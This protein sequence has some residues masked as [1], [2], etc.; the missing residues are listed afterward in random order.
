MADRRLDP[1]C[2]VGILAS[3]YDEPRRRPGCSGRT[4]CSIRVG[5]EDWGGEMTRWLLVAACA[6]V[7]VAVLLLGL[8]TLW[9]VVRIPLLVAVYFAATIV[10]SLV[11]F[12]A[13]GMD[14]RRAQADS[15]RISEKTLHWMSAAGGWSGGMLGQQVFRHKT[16]KF[17]FR[18]VYWAIVIV[19]LPLVIYSLLNISLGG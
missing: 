19:H 7:A 10:G 14:K 13:Y 1:S 3:G 2:A 5:G 11:T 6:W 8:W 9:G 17:R 12:I 15:W 18:V 16:Q 4:G